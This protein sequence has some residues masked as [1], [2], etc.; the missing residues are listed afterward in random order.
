M[1][2]AR[3][4]AGWS[5]DLGAFEDSPILEA[6]PRPLR[7]PPLMSREDALHEP[8]A[9][10]S[11]SP[12]TGSLSYDFGESSE[13]TWTCRVCGSDA[14]RLQ[15]GQWL[16][17]ECGEADARQRFN[18][19]G[20]GGWYFGNP[21]TFQAPRAQPYANPVTTSP[22]ITS[23]NGPE[24]QR[25]SGVSQRPEPRGP[26]VPGLSAGQRLR[27]EPR[28][29]VR[30]GPPPPDGDDEGY[31]DDE[32]QAESEQLTYDPSVQPSDP[33]QPPGQ[34]DLHGQPGLPGRPGQPGQP[35]PGAGSDGSRHS[36]RRGGSR[37]TPVGSPPNVLTLDD[38]KE[39]DPNQKDSS[40]S[41]STWNTLK[42]PQPGIKFRGGAVP[43]APQWHYDKS[44]LRAFQKWEKRVR[45]W[46]FQAKNYVPLRETGLLLYQ[47]LKGELEEELEDAP[48]EQLF[49]ENGVDYILGVV[50][51]AVETRAVHVKRK[52]L[53]DYQRITRAPNEAM[54]PFV[55]RYR[56][57]ER[58][59]S[60]LGINVEQ[61][62]DPEARGA[63]LL[64]RARLSHQH[65]RQILIG[66]M[67]SLEFDTVKD[68]MLFQW[69]DHRPAPAPLGTNTN[70]RRPMRP[71]KGD[72]K[73]KR[74]DNGYRTGQP[75]RRAYITENDQTVDPDECQEDD[76]LETVPEQDDEEVSIKSLKIRMLTLV[77][78]KK[79][80]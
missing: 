44:D 55:N 75:V 12:E 18:A 77:P 25:R 8:N 61:M 48:V 67:Q 34:P 26:S 24:H 51:K 78:P 33:P 15:R 72:G 42:G 69:P 46:V 23:L 80:I 14:F 28:H 35:M 68:V 52:V 32:E 71:S 11:E 76:T 47:S 58:T 5:D 60:T 6:D 65:Q 79:T 64:E 3:A 57:V 17:L 39:K 70:D 74:K 27:H 1:A 73:G 49:S 16:C 19:P 37:R 54:R 21:S 40:S 13:S 30:H 4:A 41:K 20:P 36:N 66:T 59:L 43:L 56:R 63:R 29:R 50:R 31:Y 9:D 53:A 62:Y 2:F 22:W 7:R 38:I 45:M 10:H